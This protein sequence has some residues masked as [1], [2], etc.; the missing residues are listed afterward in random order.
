MPQSLAMVLVHVIFST[1]DR[2]PCL[3]KPLRPDL[4]AYLAGILRN[5][6]CMPVEVNAV[7]DHVHILCGLGRTVSIAQLAEQVKKSSSK[8]I[9]PRAAAMRNF[10][11]QAGY[12]AFSVSPSKAAHVQRYIRGQEEHHRNVTFQEEFQAFLE[13]HG[14]AY[15]ERYVW[16]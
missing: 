14:M 1:R 16:D 3:T 4:N 12:G 6:D 5:I 2:V 11:W 15:D 7:A 8:W 9:K 10:H 13:R